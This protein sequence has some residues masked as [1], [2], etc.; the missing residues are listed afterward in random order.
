MNALAVILLRGKHITDGINPCII[1]YTHLRMVGKVLCGSA[2]IDV[3]KDN[4]AEDN[5]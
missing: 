4:L 1:G 2:W 3:T 5:F